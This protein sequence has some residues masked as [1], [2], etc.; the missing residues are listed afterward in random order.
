MRRCWWP[1]ATAR[2]CGCRDIADVTD[3]V[4]DIHNLGVFVHK[5][6]GKPVTSPAIVVQVSR[7][8]GANII[9]T[10]DRVKAVLPAVMGALPQDIKMDVAIDRTTTIRASLTDVEQTVMIATLLVVGVVAVFLMNG[11]AVLIPSVAVAVSLLGTLGVML[12]LGFSLDNLSLMAL[13]I[14]TGFVVDDAIVVLENVTRHVEAGMDRFEAALQGAQEVG[15]T[16]LSISISL[17]AVFLPILL[18]GGIFGRIFREFAI[19]LSAAV[20]I[21]LVISLTTTPMMAAYLV[22]KPEAVRASRAGSGGSPSAASTAC[23]ALYERGA[24]PGAGFRPGDP[25]HSGRHHRAQLLPLLD[26]PEGL[27]PR[28]GHRPDDRRPAGRPVHHRSRSPSG[29]CGSS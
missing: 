3:G 9:S 25:G 22:G 27:L 24:G 14:S 26:H 7:Q 15:F 11:R 4:E 2:R 16:V 6:N 23:A 18:M 29:A 10:V 19:T 5:V 21:S 13:T 8:P 28:G 1:T 20:L 17:I 12:L